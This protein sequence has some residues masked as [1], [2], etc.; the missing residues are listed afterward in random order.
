L[1]RCGFHDLMSP[2][3][4]VFAFFRSILGS[5]IV[6]PASHVFPFFAPSTLREMALYPLEPC[7]RRRFF[8]GLRSRLVV[9]P[10]HFSPP[11]CTA[12]WRFLF[13]VCLPPVLFHLLH[14]RFVRPPNF[15]LFLFLP[16]Y[17]P[18]IPGCPPLRVCFFA[19][20]LRVTLPHRAL[21][22]PTRAPPPVFVSLPSSPVES[23]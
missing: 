5:L 4:A 10:D 7:T 17:T 8:S 20:C 16:P 22:P 6:P 19:H 14:S 15:F 18:Y 3:Q 21:L 1:P 13:H 12:H 23:F 2:L 11:L 9:D